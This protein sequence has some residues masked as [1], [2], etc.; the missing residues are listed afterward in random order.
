MGQT[1][2]SHLEKMVLFAPQL[3]PDS[4]RITD[5]HTQTDNRLQK[6]N[7]LLVNLGFDVIS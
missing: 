3:P 6:I 5:N 1:N 4:I 2:D 7:P